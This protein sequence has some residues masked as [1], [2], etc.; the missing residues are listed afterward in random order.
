MYRRRNFLT[1]SLILFF[2]II[3]GI[4]YLLQPAYESLSVHKLAIERYEQDI[5]Q[6]QQPERQKEIL[7]ALANLYRNTRALEQY[8]AVLRRLIE[9]NNVHPELPQDA[10]EESLYKHGLAVAR[11]LWEQD[12]T[13]Q[14][15]QE[16]FML[17]LG[18][19]GQEDDAE[20][21]FDNLLASYEDEYAHNRL[22]PDDLRRAVNLAS[23]T[24]Q[25]ELQQT[26]LE[27]GLHVLSEREMLALFRIYLQQGASE[28][29]WQLASHITPETPS[30]MIALAHLHAT[31][32]NQAD[33]TRYYQ[34]AEQHYLA[35]LDQ[36]AGPEQ[37]QQ[38][39][40]TL[41]QLYRDIN[42]YSQYLTTV[43]RVLKLGSTDPKLLQDG[44]DVALHLWRQA[45]DDRQQQQEVLFWIDLTGNR[46]LRQDFL[47][48]NNRLAEALAMYVEMAANTPLSEDDLRQAITLARWTGDPKVYKTWLEK[49]ASIL[50]HEEQLDLVKLYAGFNEI[51]KAL[52]LAARITPQND[53]E[54]RLL[55]SLQNNPAALAGL[56][57]DG[58]VHTREANYRQQ[59]ARLKDPQARR[60]VLKELAQ[61]YRQTEQFTKYLATLKQ[62]NELGEDDPVL[63]NDGL[64]I[65][66]HL[67]RQDKTNKT[68][69]DDALLFAQY[70]QKTDFIQQFL[71]W[72][73][74]YTEVFSL[75]EEQFTN[76]ALSDDL[77]KQAVQIAHWQDDR[78]L[79]KRWLARGTEKFPEL[80]WLKELAV[81][82]AD[83]NED[84]QAQALYQRILQLEPTNQ[85]A[86]EALA[87][88]AEKAEDFQQAYTYYQQLYTHTHKT[89]YLEHM[90]GPAYQIGGAVYE[91]VLRELIQTQPTERNILELASFYVYT[92]QEYD[93]A[94]VLL[95]DVLTPGTGT[96]P[97]A[98]TPNPKYQNLLI[99]AFCKSSRLEHA[100][101]VLAKIAVPAL[102][103]ENV[104]LLSAAYQEKGQ[105]REAVALT[106]EY[107][108]EYPDNREIT[109]HLA[110]LYKR[111][112]WQDRH[113]KL[114]D[115]WQKE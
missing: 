66:L 96:G 16:N 60:P 98:P 32:G 39:L 4:A 38:I 5:L 72:N 77:L 36:A 54:K 87:Y 100:R 43:K 68:I 57:M 24:G 90:R 23:Q 6:T 107:A 50:S 30:D 26:W 89:A 61:L 3:I 95:K 91:E 85:Q 102:D 1:P 97:R 113:Q 15:K 112:G 115:S 80:E 105:W 44:L 27:R 47:V 13:N 53:E 64:E 82:S 21:F 8:V 55:A 62:L 14:V 31:Y 10:G 25:P 51:E 56:P 19:T 40:L 52:Q 94:V 65:A 12:S 108:R 20:N 46:T 83:D 42:A 114:M 73:Q 45:K 79:L 109:E 22:N 9:L 86:L 104:L 29:A 18:V 75:Y 28:R 41:A 70:A 7:I 34:E 111:L 101:E 11:D 48:W 58:D 33:A 63:F 35:A 92:T 93:K 76:G 99:Y 71:V 37:Q 78:Q 103:P 2:L 69:Q 59:L 106:E 110:Y 74:R 17:L 67:W 84:A 81:L 49:G 88:Y